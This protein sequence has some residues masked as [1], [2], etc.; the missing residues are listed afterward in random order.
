V[1][2]ARNVRWKHWEHPTK[3]KFISQLGPNKHEL[4]KIIVNKYLDKPEGTS[5]AKGPQNYNLKGE[6][7]LH[8]RKIS[9]Q[10]K[11]PHLD[12]QLT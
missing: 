5:Y 12:H 8:R 10:R 6:R 3:S 11:I 7:M 4:L 1:I 9:N 2:L